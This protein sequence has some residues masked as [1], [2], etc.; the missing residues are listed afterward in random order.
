MKTK[1][2]VNLTNGILAIPELDQAGIPYE[3]IRIQSTTLE[4][5]N[6]IKLFTDLDHNFLMNLALGNMCIVYDY[7][8]NRPYSKTI[9]IGL[10]IIRYVLNR[11]WYKIDNPEAIRYNRN[12]NPCPHNMR[13]YYDKIF[14]YL[15]IHDKTKEKIAVKLKLNYYKKY[16][17]NKSINL[18]GR[19]ESTDKDGQFEYMANL[20]KKCN[21]RI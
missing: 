10:E 13:E 2:F 12:G 9:Y 7:G 3:F 14:S 21:E 1:H 4:N 16:L 6:W 8:T 15:L 5:K 20:L 19:S 17:N 11:Y 18:E